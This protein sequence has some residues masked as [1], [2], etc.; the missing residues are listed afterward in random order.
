MP[1]VLQR[2]VG[3]GPH[4]PRHP[5]AIAVLRGLGATAVVLIASVPATA[6][7]AAP[8]TETSTTTESTSAVEAAKSVDAQVWRVVAITNAVRAR[9]GCGAVAANSRLAHAAVAH[10]VDMARRGYFAHNTLNGV[11]PGRRVTSAGYRWSAYGENIAYGQQD[12]NSV[13][14]AWMNSPGHREN[15]LNCRYRNI[16]VGLA[17]NARGVPFWTEDFG[18]SR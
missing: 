13:M 15:I 2:H 7:A 17:Y 8:P 9:A 16:G 11:D 4:S 14:L 6:A 3:R 18:R 5:A 10:S 1:F 12:A